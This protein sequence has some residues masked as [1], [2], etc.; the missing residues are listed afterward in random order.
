LKSTAFSNQV[1]YFMEITARKVPPIADLFETVTPLGR[2]LALS[3]FL[4]A[5][6]AV[7]FL[8]P[9]H[10]GFGMANVAYLD[11]NLEMAQMPAPFKNPTKSTVAENAAPNKIPAA[12]VTPLTE[13]DKLKEHAQKTLDAAAA[14]P[15]AIQEASLGL[16]IT[17]GYFGSIGKGETLR[18]DIREYYFEIL[19]RINEKW[20]LNRDSHQAGRKSAVFFLTITRNGAVIDKVLVESSGN[21]AFDRAMMQTLEAAS[22]LPPLPVTYD[23]DFFRAPL[24]F[25]MPLNLLGSLKIS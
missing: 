24:R 8:S 17:C 23:G 15:A 22:P 14:Q 6:A 4:H 16:S 11:L 25:N 12:P 1:D 20:W 18:D 10:G 3:L 7:M 2:M 21:P 13:L 19:R 5:I 9:R